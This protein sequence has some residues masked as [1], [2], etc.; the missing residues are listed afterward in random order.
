MGEIEQ[1]FTHRRGVEFLKYEAQLKR[2]CGEVT[3]GVLA[4]VERLLRQLRA[5]LGINGQRN[6]T[7]L[8]PVLMDQG[9]CSNGS[10]AELVHRIH[11]YIS[12]IRKSKILPVEDA[13]VAHVEEV[14]QNNVDA[15]ESNIVCA[16]CLSGDTTED[17]DI[18]ICDGEHTT[19]NGY[20]QKCCV[21]AALSVPTHSCCGPDCATQSFDADSCM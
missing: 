15:D 10:K 20:H 8:K 2:R 4:D 6:V 13:D 21:P 11:N 7:N 18:L 17:N 1:W 19:T 9:L 14:L 5:A 3:R 12:I 16:K